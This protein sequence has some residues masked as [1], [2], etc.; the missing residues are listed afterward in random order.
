MTKK[1]FIATEKAIGHEW[2]DALEESMKEAA[3]EEKRNAIQQ[4]SLHEGVPAISVIF[5]GGWSKRSHK[6][7]YNAKSGTSIIIGV[8]TGK[9][10][11]VGVRNKYCSVCVHTH[12]NII[13]NH[14]NMTVTRTGMV[15]PHRWK[16]TYLYRGSRRR[17]LSTVYDTLLS[18][19]TA[20]VLCMP[21]WLHKY[22]AG[23]MI[24]AK[25]S[26]PTMPSNVTAVHWRG[27]SQRSHNT[28]AG[29]SLQ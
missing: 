24:Y 16:L 29:G 18:L 17:R 26:V 21:A 22:Q 12:S 14:K 25:L 5:D 15:H 20:T 2:W 11:H 6:H 10:L 1:S 4:G 7:S 13:L 27:W 3:E 23:D 19:V 9:L 8:H 28:R